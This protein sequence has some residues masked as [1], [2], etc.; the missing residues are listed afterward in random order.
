MFTRSL[1][2]EGFYELTMGTKSK[3]FSLLLIVTLAALSLLIIQ[4]A[5]AQFIPKPSVPEFT[6]R[7]ISSTPE[8][9]SINKTI[10]LSIKNQP[11][12]SNFGF[13]YNVRMKINDV[14]WGLLYPNNNSVPNQSDGEYTILSYPSGYLGVE[15]QYHLGYKVENLTA[16]DK[17]DFQVQA[18]VGIIHRILNPNFTHGQYD[19]YPYVFTGVTSDWSNT[20]IINIPTSSSS[21]S[22]SSSVPELSFLAVIS[23]IPG[24]FSIALILSRRKTCNV[25]EI[26]LFSSNSSSI[27]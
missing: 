8:S 13:F 22:P 11:F 23:L 3:S 7:I 1:L 4:F 26:G 21:P 15:Y 2:S 27:T 5:S 24:I 9:Q 18:M 19:M 6:A 14:N 16:S 12:V 17:I 25:K 20:Q 10:E